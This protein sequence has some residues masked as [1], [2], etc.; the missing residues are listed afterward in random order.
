M[1]RIKNVKY[2]WYK[3]SKIY[4]RVPDIFIFRLIHKIGMYSYRPDIYDKIGGEKGGG[5]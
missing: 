4:K 1:L 2:Y 3:F 5:E